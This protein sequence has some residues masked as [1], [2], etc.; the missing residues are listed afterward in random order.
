M[1]ATSCGKRIR[2]DFGDLLKE[3]MTCSA[4]DLSKRVGTSSSNLCRWLNKQTIPNVAFLAQL[5]ECI[6]W[7]TIVE[8]VVS[9][10]YVTMQGAVVQ[11]AVFERM[12]DAGISPYT[13]HRKYGFS[14]G[15]IRK[16]IRGNDIPSALTLLRLAV[17]LDC[18]VGSIA[19]GWFWSVK[20]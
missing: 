17:V 2:A 7:P 16:W 9:P 18:T 1:A 4:E 10:L 12:A 14:D 19:Y 3:R 8:D 5:R 11:V 6:P 13:L 15:S 20:R